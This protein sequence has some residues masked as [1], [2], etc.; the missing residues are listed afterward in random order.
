[1]PSGMDS[2]AETYSGGFIFDRLS[3]ILLKDFNYLMTSGTEGGS[4]MVRK[5]ILTRVVI[6][7]LAVV[8]AAP[9]GVFVL[10]AARK[11]TKIAGLKVHSGISRTWFSV[12]VPC[13]GQTDAR[14]AAL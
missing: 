5:N 12:I 13:F 10:R 11:C 9:S 4:T 14:R 1:M 7:V 8:L 2:L 6:G 3:L